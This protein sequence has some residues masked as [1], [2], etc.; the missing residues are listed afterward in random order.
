MVNA[1]HLTIF[2]R[3]VTNGV[4]RMNKTGGKMKKWAIEII[5]LIPFAIIVMYYVKW[6]RLTP[7]VFFDE[8]TFAYVFGFIL[9]VVH[10]ILVK[11]LFLK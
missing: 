1:L 6:F 5:F 7:W 11:G 2:C 8:P 10:G 4:M 9:L 3:F